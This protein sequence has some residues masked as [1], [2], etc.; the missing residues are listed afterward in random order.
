MTTGKYSINHETN[1]KQPQLP[2][3]IRRIL[4]SLTWKGFVRDFDTESQSTTV[5]EPDSQTGNIGQKRVITGLPTV[6]TKTILEMAVGIKRYLREQNQGQAKR[7][8]EGTL[9][10]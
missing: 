9:K 4:A 10:P 2:Q 3:T 6:T 5:L 8:S 1:S 7:E